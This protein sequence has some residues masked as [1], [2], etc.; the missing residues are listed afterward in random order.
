[1]KVIFRILGTAA[2]VAATGAAIVIMDKLLNE[3][4]APIIES[5]EFPEEA[6][7]DDAEAAKTAGILS[8]FST[9]DL[10]GN[11]ADESIFAEYKLTM[12]NIWATFCGPCISEMPELGE[13]A[14]EYADK[15]MR[16]VGLVTDVMDSE[17]AL[18]E[19][20]LQLARDIVSETGADYL[21]IV[22]G[23]GLYGLL[24]QVSG[25]PTTLFV[26]SQGKQVGTA[27]VGA[28]DL[29]GWKTIAD[30]L[31]EGLEA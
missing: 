10:D 25:V 2:A 11:A 4:A 3:K 6:E 16:V 26:D 19:A 17:G 20:Q 21:H 18:D 12:V 13:L 1:M 27:Y 31:L 29:D 9:T 23:E 28:N 15:G 8:D 24:S 5:I 22:P 7:K 14:S 30:E